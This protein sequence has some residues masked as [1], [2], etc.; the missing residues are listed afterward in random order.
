MTICLSEAPAAVLLGDVPICGGLT[1]SYHG[2]VLCSL[3]HGVFVNY[4]HA[5]PILLYGWGDFQRVRFQ[6][7]IVKDFMEQMLELKYDPSMAAPENALRPGEYAEAT[8]LNEPEPPQPLQPAQAGG[9][10]R[11]STQPT[12]NRRTETTRLYEHSP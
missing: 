5:K 12:L 6:Y 8:N 10:L 1:T 3:L 11:S 7:E 9:S 4:S 2:C